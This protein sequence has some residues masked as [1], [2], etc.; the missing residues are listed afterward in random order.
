MVET[1]EA[2]IATDSPVRVNGSEP[3]SAADT[4]TAD[5]MHARSGKLTA[6][7]MS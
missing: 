4:G 7:H 1:A 2:P 3:N 5:S 6:A